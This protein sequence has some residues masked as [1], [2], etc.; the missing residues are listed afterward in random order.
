MNSGRPSGLKVLDY[1]HSNGVRSD[2]PFSN[3]SHTSHVTAFHAP[4][5]QLFSHLAL[6]SQNE[7]LAAGEWRPLA[8]VLG[9]PGPSLS[10]CPLQLHHLPLSNSKS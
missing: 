4:V 5:L 3:G 1:R 10:L 8:A 2:Y 9:V 6:R 7:G